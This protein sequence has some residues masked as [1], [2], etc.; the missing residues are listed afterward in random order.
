MTLLLSL[1]IKLSL[2]SFVAYGGIIAVLPSLFDL[3]V[4]QEH[5][6]NADTFADFFAIA[7][8]A[9]GPNFMTVTLIG[10]QLYGLVGAIVASIAICWPSCI[11]VFYLERYITG[12]Q[13]PEKKKIIQYASASLAVG[14]VLASS[15][16]LMVNFNDHWTATALTIAVIAATQISKI[17]PLYLIALGA[18]LGGVGFI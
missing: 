5:W 14:L 15:W 8:A 1:F 2:F 6:I 9:P 13:D 3:T 10:W 11:M 17:H 16:K 4:N 18:L 7:Q 12:I